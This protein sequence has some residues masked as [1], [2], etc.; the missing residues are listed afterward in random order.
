MLILHVSAA[1]N[2]QRNKKRLV[3]KTSKDSDVISTSKGYA[4]RISLQMG[5]Y[6]FATNT[7]FNHAAHE[8]FRK[9]CELMRPGY[10]APSPFQIGGKIL[11]TV[12]DDTRE[13]CKAEIQGQTVPM[14]LDGWSNVH[15]EPLVCCS[16]MTLSGLSILTNTVDTSGHCHTAEY[17]KDVAL[18]CIKDC[19]N[20]FGVKVRSFVTDNT[21]NVCKMRQYLQ[22]TNEISI[23]TY[24]CSA[25]L[26]NLLAQDV[27]P[28]GVKET[29]LKIIK[30]FRN[31]HLPS[32][33]Y[34]AAKGKKLIVPHEVRWNTVTDSIRSYLDNRGILVQVCQDYAA[35]ID[36]EIFEAVNDINLMKNAVDFITRT[37]PISIALDRI[38]RDSTTIG[39]AVEVWLRLERDIADQPL[40]VTKQFERRMTMALGPEHYLANICD[41]RFRGERLSEQQKNDAFNYLHHSVNLLFVPIVMA[42]SSASPPFPAYLYGKHFRSTPPMTWWRSVNITDKSAFENKWN[43]LKESWL[44]VC[45]Q[46]FSAVAAT[47]GLERIFSSFGLVQSKLRNRLSND[48]ANKLTFLFR[49]MNQELTKKKKCKS[50]NWVWGEEEEEKEEIPHPE[51]NQNKSIELVN[52]NTPV[53]GTSRGETSLLLDSEEDDSV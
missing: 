26:L 33:W 2:L 20:T 22:E 38:Q 40:I 39:V 24:G 35:Q 53:P 28:P 50:I 34:K 8:E 25:H 48:K 6:F 10:I 27:E 11:D 30:Y 52:I 18:D 29:V 36:A 42:S 15:N 44:S 51:S 43:S 17:L 1:D 14:S 19:E 31:R 41:H 12:Y 13:K 46:L 5:K 3:L 47:A 37:K 23:I 9:M 21:G 16:I 4:N 45:E 7:P 32:A 49:H